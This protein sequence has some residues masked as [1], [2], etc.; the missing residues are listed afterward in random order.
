MSLRHLSRIFV[1]AIQVVK[2]HSCKGIMGGGGKPFYNQAAKPKSEGGTGK[3]SQI[4]W[5]SGS[6]EPVK[7]VGLD[8]KQKLREAEK[9]ENIMHLICWGPAVL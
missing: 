5:V 1:R 4:R 2:D 6:R 9:A 3:S 7:Q 8:D